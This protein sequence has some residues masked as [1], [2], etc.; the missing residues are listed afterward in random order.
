MEAEKIKNLYDDF[1]KSYP[2]KTQDELWLKLSKK[3]QEFWYEKIVS[4]KSKQLSV[5]EIDE[6]VRIL[7]IKGK[8]NKKDS[9]AI[10][11][12]MIPQVAWRNLF[13]ELC[14]NKRLSGLITQ[15]F[16]E[17]N[18]EKKIGFIDQLYEINKDSRNYLTGRSGN[19]INALLA[20]FD[21]VKNLSMI[22]LRDRKMLIDYF[23]FLIPSD[24]EHRSPGF[25]FIESNR[26]I[27]ESF[28]E[29][30]VKGSAR[31]ISE[32]CYCKP[33][34]GL[35]REIVTVKRPDKDVNV[36]IPSSPDEDKDLEE[37]TDN[38]EEQRE[39]ISI[40]ALLAK[41]GSE[42]DFKIWLPKS[43]RARVLKNWKPS[44]GELLD[45]LPLNYNNAVMKTVENIDVLWLK[46]GSIIRA[47]EVEHTTSIY[48]GILRMADLLALLP[49]INIKLHIVAPIARKEK[50]FE[51]IQRPVFSLLESGAMSEFCT[52]LSYDSVHEL[53]E[54]KHLGNLKESVL[55]ELAEAAE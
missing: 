7:D 28:S 31:T 10:A 30:G 36:I 22:S 3:F 53:S 6:I 52:Y 12:V 14:S 17:N 8:G 43:D 11:A 13:Q 25:K 55:D 46:R 19:A 44:A 2:A 38:K 50:V 32:F 21:P 9:N 24:F 49:N 40:Q 27:L 41:I 51:E 26:I 39:S 45:S 16:E 20:G 47:F 23:K 29:L 37:V 5:D 34:I 1:I 15:I 33:V 18:S 54:E 42:M 4:E 48:S 35:W